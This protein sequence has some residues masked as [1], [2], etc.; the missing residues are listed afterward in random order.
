MDSERADHA[1]RDAGEPVG[2]HE[3]RKMKRSAILTSAVLAQVPGWVQQGRAADE[4]AARLGCTVGTLRVKCSQNGI[5]LRRGDHAQRQA[6]ENHSKMSIALPTSI[7]AVLDARARGQGV[8]S[9]RLAATLI[10]TIV[11]DD[12]FEAVLDGEP[13]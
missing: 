9:R 13:A 2:T 1:D 12:L 11:D 3:P 10:K 5:S 6:S 7:M 8:T 4:I